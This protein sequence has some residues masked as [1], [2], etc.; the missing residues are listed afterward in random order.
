MEKNLLIIGAGGHGRCCLDIAR[1]SKEYEKIS[2]LDDGCIGNFVNGAEV[3]DSIGNLQKYKEEYQDVFV[4]IGN[5]SFRKEVQKTAED[6]G[7]FIPKLFSKRSWISDYASVG[8]GSVIFPG[9]VIEANVTIGEGCV[10]T[11][12]AT[13]NHDAIMED[14]SLVYSNAVIRPNVIIGGLS[15]VGSGCIVTFGT[16]IEAGMDIPDGTII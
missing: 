14:Y 8:K 2:F 11:S 5:N 10:V 12:N 15:R 6:N 3:I 4:A 7:F 13:I 1:E 16:A 9:V